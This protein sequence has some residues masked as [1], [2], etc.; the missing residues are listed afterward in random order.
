[1]NT[2][3]KL[4]TRAKELIDEGQEVWICWA[5]ESCA[6][7]LGEEA[8]EL[9]RRITAELAPNILL[10]DWLADNGCPWLPREQRAMARMAWIDKLITE[11]EEMP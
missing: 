11:Y 10:T 7:D 8:A 6:E 9:V 3:V 5:L 1:M 2:Y 4:L